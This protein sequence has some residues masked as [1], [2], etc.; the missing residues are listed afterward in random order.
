[1]QM[2]PS[3]PPPRPLLVTSK[4]QYRL[5]TQVLHPLTC[6][7]CYEYHMKV[8][9]RYKHYIDIVSYTRYISTMMGLIPGTGTRQYALLPYLYWYQYIRLTREST[10]F[11]W[12]DLQS[13]FISE[14]RVPR[15]KRK[16]RLLWTNV[17]DE[18]SSE[19]HTYRRVT[20]RMHSPC[21]REKINVELHPRGDVLYLACCRM[22]G[23][24]IEQPESR[25][26][27]GLTNA[28]SPEVGK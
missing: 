19:P 22:Y 13:R 20:R 28:G 9:T 21:C 4:T 23:K 10:L 17:V 11:L 16:L 24:Y 5:F 6:C 27:R 1:M 15:T 12:D 2:P 3:H 8:H 14:T 18:T 25:G 7:F 26:E